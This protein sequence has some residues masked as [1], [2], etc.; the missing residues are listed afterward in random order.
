MRARGP[1]DAERLALDFVTVTATGTVIASPCFVYSMDYTLSD[2]SVSG[3]FSFG[4][5]S[6]SAD[7]V[8]ESS[9]MDIKTNC[10]VASGTEDVHDNWTFNPPLIIQTTL[11]FNI[12]TGIRS[13]SFSYLSAS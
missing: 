9:R 6:A 12:A 13:V 5:T 1:S 10:T 4:D 7:L 8:K 2:T 3:L 11:C